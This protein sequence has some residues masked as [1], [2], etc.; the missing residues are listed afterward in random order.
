MP[1]THHNFTASTLFTYC[2]R[3][4]FSKSS[5]APLT[6]TITDWI[7]YTHR[8]TTTEETKVKIS[9]RWQRWCGVFYIRNTR[10]RNIHI[11]SHRIQKMYFILCV[12]PTWSMA[13]VTV[14][15]M[16]FAVARIIITGFIVIAS[17]YRN[18]LWFCFDHEFPQTQFS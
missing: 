4:F 8:F 15:G 17:M 12:L 10:N 2:C 16:Y 5:S 6:D 9:L 7:L 14:C 18:T 11:T 13:L 1:L 3:F